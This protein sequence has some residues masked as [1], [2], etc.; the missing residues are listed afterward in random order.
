MDCLFCEISQGTQPGNI[1]A[2]YNNCYV[3]EDKFPISKGHLLIIPKK[4]YLQWFSAPKNVRYEM[5]EIADFMKAKL[6]KTLNPTGYNVGMNC[7]VS[8][9]QTVMHLH[10]HII[11]R[12]D[13]DTPN[14]AGGIR[15][16]LMKD[17]HVFV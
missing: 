13:G 14:P 3:L 9:G 16:I 6:D 8:A 11:P 1:I 17:N 4:H 10:M 2:A 15:Q 5:I 12:Y 7:G